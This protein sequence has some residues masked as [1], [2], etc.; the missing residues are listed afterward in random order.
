EHVTRRLIGGTA[1]AVNHI[2]AVARARNALRLRL[3]GKRGGGGGGGARGAARDGA[4]SGRSGGSRRSARARFSRAR[5]DSEVSDIARWNAAIATGHSPR[6][7]WAIP[8][9]VAIQAFA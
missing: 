1:R 4:G 7:A 8:C 2:G 6:R 5:S 3:G 9:I